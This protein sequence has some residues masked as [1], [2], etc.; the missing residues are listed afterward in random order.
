MS[1]ITF[2]L[3]EPLLLILLVLAVSL[4]FRYRKNRRLLVVRTVAI[5][6]LIFL[7]AEPLISYVREK[8]VNPVIP[9][10]IDVSRS[11]VI[12]DPEAKSD[13]L[14]SLVGR[15]ESI[16]KDRFT[17]RFFQF[18]SEVEPA[19]DSL[20]WV[21]EGTGLG[22]AIE[23]IAKRLS[24]PGVVLVTDGV[25]NMGKYPLWVA[26]YTDFPLFV[27]GFGPPKAKG[28]ASVTRVRRNTIVYAEDE[29]P[30]EVW[31]QADGLKGERTTLSLSQNE[32]VIETKEVEFTDD[33]EERAVEFELIPRTPG[34]MVFEIFINPLDGEL[35]IEN[36]RRTFA[37]KVLKSKNR[38][39]YVSTSPNW[40][41][42]FLRHH[43]ETDPATEFHSY[44]RLSEKTAIIHPDG[45]SI[46][47][48]KDDLVKYDCLILHNVP[49]NELP[50][51]ISTLLHQLVGDL[52]KSLLVVGGERM[53]GYSGSQVE[54]MLP[55]LFEE[56]VSTTPFHIE[57]T[58]EGR[59]HPVVQSAGGH[60]ELPPLLGCN[61][62]RGVKPGGTVWAINPLIQTAQ[63][64]LPVMTQSTYGKGNVVVITCFPLWRWYFLM[65]GLGKEPTFYMRFLTNILRWL[66]TRKDINR[67]VVELAQ[68]AYQTF[69]E[70][71]FA[72]ELYDEDYRPVDGAFV[73][74]KIEDSQ[75]LTLK[76]LGAGRYTGTVSNLE[77]GTYTFTA[78]AYVE[79]KEYARK[80]GSLD[81]VEGSVESQDFGLQR[82]FLERISSL[83]GGSYYTP[84]S[85]A[86]L[87]QIRFPGTETKKHLTLELLYW[88]AIYLIILSLLVAEWGIRRLRGL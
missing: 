25:S 38:I 20:A 31:I 37:L 60:G 47:L 3:K 22:D 7:I 29:V 35:N 42:R 19:T 63:G 15:I 78:L 45:P 24:P 50:P 14:R 74:I 18:S 69:E 13:S 79:G 59:E 28:D 62:L 83:T 87:S 80:R 57:F 68:P 46:P 41:Y 65:K 10:L 51:E 71:E 34:T 33:L 30:V 70:I 23:E 58:A 53:M 2:S 73:R 56:K 8:Q 75:E 52:G 1:D 55:V 4:W 66:S 26:K 43:M 12:D 39:L 44:I 17:L 81:V 85:I 9:V 84:E 67:L 72:T 64:K 88:P 27:V 61:R 77:P 49:A 82:E 5:S 54:Q 21:H 6:L 40:E 36:N 11:M 48:V 16:L 32:R 86:G 76:P